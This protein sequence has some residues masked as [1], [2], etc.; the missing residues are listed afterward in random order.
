MSGQAIHSEGTIWSLFCLSM[1]TIVRGCCSTQKFVSITG[2]N[3]HVPFYGRMI[4][5]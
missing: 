5:R 3:M 4:S 2:P 1:Y